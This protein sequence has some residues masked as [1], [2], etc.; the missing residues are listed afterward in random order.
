[1]KAV[2]LLA[3]ALLVAAPLSAQNDRPPPGG[4]A[5]VAPRDSLIL[6]IQD[7][8][9][10]Q[11]KEQL[12]LTDDQAEKLKLTSMQWFSRHRRLES[13]ERQL[14]AALAT[15]MRPGVAADQDSVGRLVDELFAVK[16]SQVETYRD[17]L[18]AMDYL[19]PVQRAQ[20]FILRDRV[21]KRIQEAREAN[22]TAPPRLR[23]RP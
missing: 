20:F 7:R 9:A 13:R 8:L 15:Q 17:E 4:F 5:P 12:G 3:L 19:T 21:L 2:I 22:D 18:D 16:V 11:V 10:R 6:M 23:R 14:R 1:M